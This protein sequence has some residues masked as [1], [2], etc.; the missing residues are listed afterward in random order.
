MEE[1]LFVNRYVKRAVKS[2]EKE[3]PINYYFQ[4]SSHIVALLWNHAVKKKRYSKTTL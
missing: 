3:F 1:I 4:D 2:E